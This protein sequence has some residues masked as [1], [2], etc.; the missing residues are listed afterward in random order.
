M[1]PLK[2][3]DEIKFG[4]LFSKN[5]LIYAEKYHSQYNIK[6]LRSPVKVTEYKPKK[7]N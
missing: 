6:K 2:K 3:I 4:E 7:N 1:N 5:D